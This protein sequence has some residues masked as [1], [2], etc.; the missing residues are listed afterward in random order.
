MSAKTLL[1]VLALLGCFMALRLDI[2]EFKE[3]G[4]SLANSKF[5]DVLMTKTDGLSTHEVLV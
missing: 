1:L 5:G 2:E 4:Y 3:L